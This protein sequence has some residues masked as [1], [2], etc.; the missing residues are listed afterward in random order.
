MT[1]TE[2]TLS[3]SGETHRPPGPP[4]LGWIGFLRFVRSMQRDAI[5]TVGGRFERYGDMYLSGGRDAPLLVTRHPDHFHDVLVSRAADFE[6]RS[7]DLG[8]F[9]GNGLLTANGEAWR[10]HRRSIQPGF[11]R[12]RLATYA[13]TI[14]DAADAMLDDWAKDGTRDVGADMSRLTL[15]VVG[16]ALF[17]YDPGGRVEQVAACMDVLQRAVTQLDVFPSWVPTPLHRRTKNAKQTLDRMMFDLIEARRADPRRGDAP[18]LLGHLISNGEMSDQ[19][20][21]DE[22]LT[23]FLA[24]YETTSL[25]LMWTWWQLAQQRD[26]ERQVIEEVDRVLEGRAPNIDDLERLDVTRRVIC[27]SMRIYPPVYA[28]PRVA[29]RDTEL[30]GYPVR[31][32]TELVLWVYWAHHDGRWFP[33]PERFD[34]DRFLPRAAGMQHPHAYL[35]FGAGSRTCIGRHFAMMEAQLVLARVVQRFTLRSTADTAALGMRPRITLG[36]AR[37]VRMTAHPRR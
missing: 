19:Q 14:I 5:G 7:A 15:A 34:P 27:E 9:L 6:K 32:G 4:P 16:K 8:P 30:G 23:L 2:S 29:I 10:S 1:A 13:S 31:A 20:L 28:I 22:L 12:E 21:R 11:R 36:P 33:S 17:D 3:S 18:D 35:P 25:A 26:W 37:R 24:G